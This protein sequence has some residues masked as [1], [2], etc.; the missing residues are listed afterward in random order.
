[1][2]ANAGT[3]PALS[4]NGALKTR[5]GDE[6]GLGD[7]GATENMKQDPTGLEDIRRRP[8][9]TNYEATTFFASSAAR[10]PSGLVG[11]LHIC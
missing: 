2:F 4:V 11:K 9:G 7:S 5:H 6:Y 10:R 8:R 1:M 3:H